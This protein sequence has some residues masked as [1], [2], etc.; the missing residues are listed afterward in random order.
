MKKKCAST[1]N[2]YLNQKITAKK[3]I[4]GEKNELTIG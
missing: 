3:H 1:K 2:R 4:K